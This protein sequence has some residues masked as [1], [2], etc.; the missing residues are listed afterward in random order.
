[1]LGRDDRVTEM[2]MMGLRLIEPIPRER[3]LR[4][5]GAE[6][7]AVLDATDAWTR[8]VAEAFSSGRMQPDEP[9][10]SCHVPSLWVSHWR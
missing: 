10:C 3:F 9:N 7:E 1:M 8:P 2:L 5:A 4:I 6:P